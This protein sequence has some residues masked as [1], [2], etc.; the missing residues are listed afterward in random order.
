MAAAGVP[1]ARPA[2]E[3]ATRPTPIVPVPVGDAG[4]AVAVSQA[5]L[6][7]GLLVPA[8]RPPTVPVGSSRLR[9]TVCSEHDPAQIESVAVALAGVLAG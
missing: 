3:H 8:V 4:R 6:E 9:L 7:R 2:S 1:M 5:L